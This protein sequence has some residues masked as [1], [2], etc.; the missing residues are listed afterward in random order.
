MRV[1]KLPKITRYY[2]PCCRT[3]LQIGSVDF[4]SHC[5]SCK[6]TKYRN[7]LINCCHCEKTFKNLVQYTDHVIEHDSKILDVKIDDTTGDVT[8]TRKELKSGRKKL[9]GPR[10]KP[11]PKPVEKSEKFCDLC[12]KTF[13]SYSTFI[14]H[15]HAVHLTKFTGEMFK[16]KQCDFEAKAKVSVRTHVRNVHKVSPTDCPHCGKTF[17]TNHRMLKHKKFQHERER[18]K[19][20]CTICPD[21]PRFRSN[22]LLQRHIALTH[23]AVSMAMGFKCSVEGCD[24]A[25]AT[26]MNLNRHLENSHGLK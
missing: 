16:C 12:G 5:L 4:R 19:I 25:Y 24:A 10:P 26:E 9:I 15:R 18:M 6:V 20:M 23:G 8:I 17:Q 14:V 11:N 13:S 3:Y 21:L 22:N 2:C 7:A 1:H